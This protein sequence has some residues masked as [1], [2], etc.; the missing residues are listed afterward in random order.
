MCPICT[1]RRSAEL[2]AKWKSKHCCHVY[3]EDDTAVLVE[4]SSPL[5]SKLFLQTL[6]LRQEMVWRTPT[7]SL[8]VD[9]TT[10]FSVDK[11][12]ALV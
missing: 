5:F 9:A 12:F 8:S 10:H 11:V 1:S 2:P 6:M 7:L 4:C 3:L